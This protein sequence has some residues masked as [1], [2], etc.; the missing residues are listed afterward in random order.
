MKAII[1]DVSKKELVGGKNQYVKKGEVAITVPVLEDLLPFIGAKVTGEEDGLPVYDKDEANW[2]QSAML[3]YVKASARNKLINGTA[4]VKE[5][6][7]IPTNWEE[8]CA[9]GE[10]GGN[11]AALAIAREAKQAF[12]DWAAKQGKSEA[13]TQ[14]LVTLFSNRA[15]LQVQ[16]DI[17]KGKMK[18]YVESFAE[19]L[20]AQEDGEA[21]VERFQ[22][23]IE[24]V[25]AACEAVTAEDF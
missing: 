5:G 23:T 15:A 20:M 8:L 6:Q 7:K 11:G 18:A 2:L 1:I 17:N 25:L 3:S 10:R 16:N 13:A 4:Q 12:A 24:G 21:L 14:T 22:R 19:S 9:E